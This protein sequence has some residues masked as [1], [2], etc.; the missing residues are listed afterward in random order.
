MNE[1]NQTIN[2]EIPP[3]VA[4]LQLIAGFWVSHAISIAAKLGIADLL[5][6]QSKSSE[7]LAAATG[8]HAPSLYRVLRALASVGVFAEYDLPLSVFQRTTSPLPTTQ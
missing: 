4:M 7:E 2:A 5:K 1:P 3:P 6:D 8:T